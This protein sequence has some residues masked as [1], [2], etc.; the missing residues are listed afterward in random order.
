MRWTKA[1][2]LLLVLGSAALASAFSQRSRVEQTHPDELAGV[3]TVFID[4]GLDR[5]SRDMIVTEIENYL[6]DLIIVARPEGADIHLKFS[7]TVKVV[8][9]ALIPQRTSLGMVF[10]VLDDHRLRVLM[11]YW[12]VDHGLKLGKPDPSQEFAEEFVKA[13]RQAN[14]K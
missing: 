6:P 8:T 5:Q 10:K 12:R 11:R 14:R 7:L 9:P 4:T 13:Y 3:T 1:F 2:F